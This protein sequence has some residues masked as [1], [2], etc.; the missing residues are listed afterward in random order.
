MY[1]YLKARHVISHPQ[2]KPT[3]PFIAEI[4]PSFLQEKKKVVLGINDSVYY[5]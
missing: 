2:R 1:S 5:L 3:A 4:L